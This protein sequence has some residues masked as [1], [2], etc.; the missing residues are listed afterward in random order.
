MLKVVRSRRVFACALGLV[1]ALSVLVEGS[2]AYAR[3]LDVWAPASGMDEAGLQGGTTSSLSELEA[4]GEE[5]DGDGSDE[6][7]EG[8]DTNPPSTDDPEVT[9][10][11]ASPEDTDDEEDDGEGQDDPE[12]PEEPEDPAQPEEPVEP[13][14]P[15]V[16]IDPVEPDEPEDPDDLGQPDEPVEPGQPSEPEDEE[17]PE[18]PDDQDPDLPDEPAS[19]EQPDEQDEPGEPEEPVQ[20]G[21]PSSPEEQDEPEK[22][23]D[24]DGEDAASDEEAADEGTQDEDAGREGEDSK[25]DPRADDAD[26]KEGEKDS[27]ATQASSGEFRDVPRD[28][29]AWEVIRRSVKLGLFMGYSGAH[30]GE[31]GPGD[32]VTRAQAV[33]VLWRMAGSPEPGKHP[34]SFSDVKPDAWYYKAVTWASSKGVVN[35]Y[36]GDWAGKFGPGDPV[37]REQLAAM[38]SNYAS[39]IAK[40]S[41]SGSSSSYA[42]MSDSSDVS[43]WAEKPVGWCF[44]CGLMSGSGG[45]I[46]PKGGAT[47]AQAAKMLVALY[48]RATSPW[49]LSM[50][51][52]KKL[53][54]RG[55]TVQMRPVV[56]G[57]PGEL[58][59]SYAASRGSWSS[60]IPSPTMVLD[61]AGSYL[62]TIRA[63]DAKGRSQAATAVVKAYALESLK[64]SQSGNGRWTAAASIG[65]SG[66]VSGVEYRF[67]WY[68]NGTSSGGTLREWA[69]GRTAS[70]DAARL[71]NTAGTFT[72]VVEARDES[73]SLGTKEASL[74]ISKVG[75]QNPLPYYQLSALDVQLPYS[76]G[77]IFGYVTPSQIKVDSGRRACVE[78]FVTRAYDYLGTPYIWDYACAP[79]VGV[80]C[81]GLVLQCL[82][83]VGI[84]PNK[85]TPWDHFYTPGHDHYAVDMFYDTHFKKVPFSERQRGDLIFYEGH[86][87]IYLGGDRIINAVSPAVGV[88]IQ[89]VH[90]WVPIGCSRV[91]I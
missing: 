61:E 73:G 85:Y 40:L 65:L 9:D 8:D 88:T 15:D 48:D 34:K 67:T 59:Y 54:R 51:V 6:D 29:W 69:S 13:E 30:E 74:T 84:T 87:A 18:A 90:S 27:L 71:G 25:E 31:F 62:L 3:A 52:D 72:I 37:T 1:L 38:L 56:T 57:K 78:A 58:T 24:E 86:V 82:Y 79:G 76:G 43:S 44:T 20:P 50:K 60:S 81:A 33:T 66:S 47:R 63:K 21:D 10:E 35:G 36:S 64:V 19:P 80:D 16:P 39:R 41:V 2:S 49:Q 70:F 45:K 7:P 17:Q 91:M 23:A 5:G 55:A 14:Q 4:S 22:P 46:D 53:A 42:A 11:A 75:Y 68:K 83:A 77:G 26:A 32:P 89:D 28:H 12:S